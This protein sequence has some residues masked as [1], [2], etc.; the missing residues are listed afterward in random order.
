MAAKKKRLDRAM[1]KAGVTSPDGAKDT[2]ALS[3]QS[4][5]DLFVRLRSWFELELMR[6]QVNRFQMALDCDY[7]D[8]I[9]WQTAEA[10]KVRARGQAP[11]VYNEVKPTVDW[12]IGTERRTRRD[13]KV[14]S[15][16][17]KAPEAVKDAEIKTQFLK[18]LDDVGRGP[19]VRSQSFDD[20]VKA[21]LGWLEVGVTADPEDE[22][23]YMRSESWR[24]MLHDS[25]SATTSP[26]PNEWRYVFRFKEI[27]LDVAEAYFP[28]HVEELR[29]A[30]N[31]GEFGTPTDE[32]WAG[33]W[34][35][36]NVSQPEGLPMR[37]MDFN[38]DAD[39]WNPRRRVSLVEC[40]YREPTRKTT[41]QGASSQDRV[42][43]TTRVAIFTKFDLLLD[44][45]SPYEHNRFPFIP[46]WCYR[47]KGDGMPYGVVRNVRG[48]QDGLNKR[49]SKAQF[50]LSVNQLMVE[51]GAI[52]DEVMD[53][54][55]IRHEMAAPDGIAKFAKGALSGQKVI[56]T[57]GMDLAQGHLA[58]AERDQM[59]IRASSGVTSENRGMSANGQSGK[60]IIA[61]QDQGSMVTAEVFDNLMLAH[62]I[63]GELKVS[64]TE[65]YVTDEK[66]FSVTGER[67][68]LDFY[69]MNE[70][71]PST[72]QKVNDVT[73]F[74]ASF[75]IGEA[76]WKQALAEASFESAMQML[77]QIAQA[78][79]QVVVSIL[80][81][82]FEWGD[83]PNKQQILQRIRSVTGVSDPDKG[84]TPEQQA[85]KQQKAAVAKAQFE[86]QMAQLQATIREAQ[87]KGEKLSAEAIA[88]RLEALYMAAQA[89]QV[90]TMAPQIAPVADELARS[91]GFKDQAGDA[92]LGGPVP[93]QPSQPMPLALQADGALAGAQAGIESPAVSGVD[94]GVMQ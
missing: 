91:V 37:W 45:E 66:T 72:G 2:K 76:P 1:E 65:Q 90:L 81:L 28:N 51:E 87:A 58:L 59:A 10:A 13:F 11:I 8:G 63:E 3:E 14:L 32:E 7:Y 17:S 88:K 18:Y 47:R 48:P 6:Q 33:A 29:R 25:I 26:D 93:T 34:P 24:N 83:F 62:Q 5:R 92:A 43:K 77:G 41:G 42:Y 64:L 79:P 69:T 60:A 23:I 40:W 57:S 82:V 73:R 52:D 55:E 86:A 19:F 71:D 53:E 12:L 44:I 68:K 30:A 9:Q 80:D 84:D 54:E 85:E 46:L 89:A 70:V 31:M 22:Q 16:K 94:Q 74:K 20:Q 21:G 78:A 38:P 50:L 35:T 27:D 67:Y 36:A 49:M 75:V 39:T 56:R 61:K 4:K 15:R